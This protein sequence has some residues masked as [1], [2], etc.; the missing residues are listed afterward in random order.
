MAQEEGGGTSVE[1]NVDGDGGV[2]E[3]TLRRA[4]EMGWKPKEKYTG[5]EELW[6]PADEYVK[7]GET[8]LP[9]V[10]AENRKLKA[11]VA[12]LRESIKQQEANVTALQ[13]SAVAMA[14]LQHDRAMA[15]LKAQKVQALK[16]NDA[17]AQV[18]ID[19][20]IEELKGKEPTAPKAAAKTAPSP[21]STGG[22]DFNSSYYREIAAAHPWLDSNSAGDKEKVAFAVAISPGLISEGLRGQELVERVV[23]RVEEVFSPPKR[24][25]AGDKM[26]GSRGGAG[27]SSGRGNGTAWGDLPAEAQAVCM[28][29]AG[30]LVGA[31]KVHK[32]LASWKKSFTE[33]YFA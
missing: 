32:D 18:E 30:R 3:S 9:I 6:V 24:R 22:V 13:E 8:V 21:A 20:A 19:E 27:T 1:E 26:E 23:E 28:K 33:Q 12:A 10:T 7:R 25:P 5:R 15:S 2:D 4:A 11:E 17:E 29:Q 16:D 14:K 31:G